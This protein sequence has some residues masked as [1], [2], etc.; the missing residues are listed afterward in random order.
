MTNL[1][2]VILLSEP[3]T[4]SREIIVGN[5]GLK[6]GRGPNNDLIL[7]QKIIS[8][9]HFRLVWQDDKLYLEDRRSR[10]GTY[11][12]GLRL[13]ADTKQRL[14]VDDRIEIGA[15]NNPIEFR[16]LRFEEE[17]QLTPLEK[18]EVL[19]EKVEQL[20]TGDSE[21]PRLSD[22][23][24]SSIE[25]TAS[26]SS[27]HE[28]VPPP[29]TGKHPT[30][31]NY[32]PDI[33]GINPLGPST[34]M[35]Y[36]PEMYSVDDFIGRFLLIF[37]SIYNP[38]EW[39]VEH[40]DMYLSPETAPE[41]WLQWMASWFDVLI[42]PKLEVERQREV[43]GQISWLFFRRGTKQGLE[44]LLSLYFNISVH[45]VEDKPCHFVVT[46][47]LTHSNSALVKAGL[48]Q[49]IAERLIISQKPDFASFDLRIE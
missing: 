40:F 22:K 25:V 18:F 27:G 8:R 33:P 46:L 26:S 38:L 2:A 29:P 43:L 37:E 4:D 3:G 39:Y 45:I 48:G 28:I 15:R 47:P 42:H 31:A 7:L 13:D 14:N 20:V 1:Q 49:A 44:R 9:D 23:E 30:I 5:S 19:I 34:W 36:L 16:L 24:V 17:P 32:N 10:E 6:V 21:D 11:L 41:L 12:N 35:Q